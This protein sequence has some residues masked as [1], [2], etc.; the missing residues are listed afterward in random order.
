[1]DVPSTVSLIVGVVSVVVAAF[2]M[3]QANAAA[4]ESRQ[5]FEKTRD[6]LAEIDKRAAVTEQIVAEN[7][8]DLLDT[9]KKLAIP[10]KPDMGQ[11]IG[12][13]IMTKLL[14][15]PEG[16]SN[17]LEQFA[18]LAEFGNQSSDAPPHQQG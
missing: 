1:M 12:L 9:V 10:E 15:N 14:E 18:K 11:E 7:Q 2:A 17:S 4:K 3:R 8:R 5:N 16:M 6:L 13:A